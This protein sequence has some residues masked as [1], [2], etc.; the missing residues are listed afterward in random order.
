MAAATGWWPATAASS[1][2][3][4]SGSTGRCRASASGIRPPGS[5]RRPPRAGTSSRPRRAGST[6]SVTRPTSAAWPKPSPATAAASS[7]WTAT[8]RLEPR[9]AYAARPMEA[10]ERPDVDA[11]VARLRAKVEQRRQQGVYPPGLEDELD[12]HFRRIA[13]HRVIPDFS[14]VEQA[15]AAMEAKATFSVGRIAT[16]SGVPGGQLVHR[17]LA[18]ALRRQT[19][20][21]LAQVQ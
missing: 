14:A 17:L 15:L 13:A 18:K 8:P 9:N 20:G 19:E 5:G 11:L 16:A 7:D 6:A 4:T 21:I 10:P 3:A 2:S 12:Q 1:A